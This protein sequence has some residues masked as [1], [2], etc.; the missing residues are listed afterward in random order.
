MRKKIIIT[1]LYLI[2]TVSLSYATHHTY[3]VM[4][5]KSGKAIADCDNLKIYNDDDN[6]FSRAEFSGCK[7][8]P[9]ADKTEGEGTISFSRDFYY[10]EKYV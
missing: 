2:T 10:I 9:Y 5:M 4:N 1:M 6:R 3:T 7:Q 8:N